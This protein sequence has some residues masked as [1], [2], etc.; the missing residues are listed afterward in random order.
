[1]ST[2]VE[3]KQSEQPWEADPWRYGWR[4]VEEQQ[5]DGTVRSKQIPLT[6]LDI[7]HP[8]EE[9]FI[10]NNPAHDRDCD[11]LKQALWSRVKDRPGV[12]VLRDCRVDWGVEGIEAH[13]PDAVVLEGVDEW[14]PTGGTFYLA[15]HQARPVLAVEITSP[16]TR[17]NDLGVKVDEYYRAGIPL[18]VIVDARVVNGA[19]T[20][21]IIGRQATKTGYAIL[22]LDAHGRL[23]LEP[24]GLWLGA[25]EGQLVCT[26]AQGK[27]LGVYL[28][29]EQEAAAARGQV[30]TA[31]A[32]AETAQQQAVA[33]IAR[34]ETA[35][36]QVAAAQ[37]QVAAAI[38]R[39]EAARGE[40]ETARGETEIAQRHT[41]T[42]IAL[43][44]AA[45]ARADAEKARA[46]VMQT[47]N[48]ALQKRL[49][50]LEA[51]YR[52]RQNPPS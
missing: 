13:G 44:E 12:V 41:R 32:R 8:Q 40:T 38:A 23:W 45:I 48:E 4:Y 25:E 20:M 1:M 22:P 33:A 15:A 34:A 6:E 49:L 42:A 37:Q 2:V 21:R 51:E 11:V 9:D 46:A 30:E 3:P 7:L 39:A 16:S 47:E 27:R 50:E 29:M 5:P 43:A 14:D 31:I 18:Y 17:G 52:K 35:Q 24:V 10:M 36:R 26:D 28:E 19:R